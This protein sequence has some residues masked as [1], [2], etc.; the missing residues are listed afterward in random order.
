MRSL[1]FVLAAALLAAAPAQ[2]AAPWGAASDASTAEQVGA[3]RLVFDS[4]GRTVLA[5]ET[6]D[7]VASFTEVLTEGG[8]R[9][10]AGAPTG[11]VRSGDRSF[12]LTRRTVQRV[13]LT[14]LTG[15][16]G[17]I[18]RRV[19]AHAAD[20]ALASN[21]RG[22]GAVAWIDSRRFQ[23]AAVRVRL[24]GRRGRLGRTTTLGR[25]DD[26]SDV[27]V[28]VGPRGQVAVLWSEDRGSR[29]RVVARVR[30][31]GARRFGR[32]LRLGRH[33]GLAEIDATYLTSG[34]LAVAYWS[35]DPGEEASRPLEVRWASVDRSARR[36][37]ARALL[38]RGSVAER[39]LGAVNLEATP[40]GATVVYAMPA[41]PD[42]S[43]IRTASSGPLGH[44][45]APAVLAPAGALGDLV[46]GPTGTLLAVWARAEGFVR[47]AVE[48]A[49][50]PLGGGFG[51]SEE[52][53]REEVAAAPSAAFSPATGRPTAVWVGR[54]GPQAPFRIR[55]A[56]RTG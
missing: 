4:D 35:Q 51:A 6:R 26:I 15:K 9:Q 13:L 28:A 14:H 11:L 53:S 25:A 30:D 41:A 37:L 12:L 5:F 29:R 50:K 20:H 44:F 45:G 33:A 54:A 22:R 19:T 31:R 43:E 3:P 18:G 38:D 23:A 7:G 16:G 2:A 39:P 46:Q 32:L 48:A 27:D 49:V 52:V 34:R 10:L 55:T 1:P 21:L 8:R 56:E 42:R 17:A 47:T 24:A 40:E 36:V